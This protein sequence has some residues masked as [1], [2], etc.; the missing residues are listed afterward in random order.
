MSTIVLS[1]SLSVALFVSPVLTAHCGCFLCD[2]SH[3]SAVCF[4]HDTVQLCGDAG[5][6][7]V[8]SS[9]ALALRAK[10]TMGVF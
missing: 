10:G 8:L 7:E 3:C 1:L 4:V 2:Q 5:V 9:L 6:N